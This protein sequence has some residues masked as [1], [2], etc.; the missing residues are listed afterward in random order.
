MAPA[1]A[2]P[3]RQRL[4]FSPQPR[5]ALRPILWRQLE[6]QNLTFV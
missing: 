5:P 1:L 6:Q 4:P 3:R 2:Q